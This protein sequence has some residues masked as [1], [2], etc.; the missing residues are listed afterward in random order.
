VT[1][2][3]S[4]FGSTQGLVTFNGTTAPIISW[5]ASSTVAKVPTGASSGNVV[6]TAGASASN[7]VYFNVGTNPT[8]PAITSISPTSGVV[9]ASVTI[10]GTSFGSAAGTVT[11][12]GTTASVLTWTDSSIV[13]GVPSGA[14]SGNVIVTTGGSASNGVYFNV[15]TNPTTPAI[16]SLSPSS[17]VVGASVTITGS[18]FGSTPGTVTFAGTTASV[19][20]WTDSSI[21]AKVPSGSTTGNV[22]VTVNGSASNGVNFTVVAQSPGSI[23]ASYFGMQ[24]GVG[25]IPGVNN[26]PNQPGTHDPTWPTSVAQP[27]VLRLWD[28]Q[29]AWS[30]LMIGYSGGVGTYDWTQL[31]GYLDVIA[32]NQPRTVSYVFGCVP[33]FAGGGPARPI[34]SCGTSGGATPPSDLIA[35]GSPTFTQFVTD[36]LN[37]CS[38]AGNCVKTYIKNYELWNEAN[39]NATDPHPRWDGTQ[40]QLYQM[41]AAAV[42]VIRAHVTGATIFTPSITSGNQAATWMTGWLNAEIAGGV[43]SDVYNSHQYLNN[44]IPESVLGITSTDLG[45]NFGTLGWTPLPWVI[46][47]AGYDDLTLP[48]DCNAGNTGTQF[49]TDDCV[50]QMVRWN[51]LLFSNAGGWGSRGTGLWWY[52]WNTYIGSQPQ[53]AT[54]Y[55]YMMQYLLGGKFGGPCVLT[56]GTTW[57]CPFTEANGTLALW[58]WTTDENGASFTVPSGYVDYVDLTGAK[59]ATSGGLS[60]TISVLPITLEQ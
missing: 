19:A 29:V 12:N 20:S 17:G 24:C 35:S 55:S 23:T 22:V 47:E 41:V 32:A 42:T 7:G 46:G 39:I 44:V 48:Y 30:W 10:S 60:I 9:G 5:T 54:A 8:P 38:P 3:G 4:N 53:Y 56:S 15:V 2:T 45:P 21:V 13:A 18:N 52:Y 37:H 16:T 34:G 6:V 40:T 57:T 51:L 49:T 50:G 31:D 11:F 58:V 27:G 14:S 43:I 36:L 59:T 1:I 28:S 25:Y 33:L 26:C